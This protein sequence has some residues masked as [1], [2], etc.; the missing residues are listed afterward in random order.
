MKE[1]SKYTKK[2]IYWTDWLCCW[3]QFIPLQILTP[4]YQGSA[5]AVSSCPSPTSHHHSKLPQPHLTGEN[6]LRQQT[7]AQFQCS[8]KLS[9]IKTCLLK[10]WSACTPASPFYSQRKALLNAELKGLARVHITT[11]FKTFTE[12]RAEYCQLIKVKCSPSTP[13]HRKDCWMQ[14]K[15]MAMTLPP[16]DF[17]AITNSTEPAHLHYA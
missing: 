7:A 16:T 14:V 9:Q 3:P 4:Y 15:P 8:N 13:F 2:I 10:A 12:R 6:T 5:H 17:T 11:I 1:W